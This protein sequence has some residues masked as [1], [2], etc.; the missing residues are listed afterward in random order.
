MT[1]ARVSRRL[2]WGAVM[3]FAVKGLVWLV[4]AAAGAAGL[5]GL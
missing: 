1:L 3:F 5:V 2:G 4:I